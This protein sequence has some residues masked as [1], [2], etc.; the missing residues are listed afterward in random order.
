MSL[1]LFFDVL[2]IIELVVI[3]WVCAFYDP[4]PKKDNRA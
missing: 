4:K 3:F 2:Y 1:D